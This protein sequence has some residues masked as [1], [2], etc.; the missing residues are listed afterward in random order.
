[1]HI[2]I[3]GPVDLSPLRRRIFGDDPPPTYSFPLVGQLA[4]ALLERGHSLSIF[5]GSTH[6]S[7]TRKFEGERLRIFACPLRPRRSA[8]DF[9]AHERKHLTRAMLESGCDLIHAHWTYE[10]SA[11]AIESGIPSLVTA[12]DSPL[13]ILRYFV[14]TRHFPFWTAKALLGAIVTRRA[15]QMTAVSPYCKAHIIRLLRPSAPIS[16]VPNGIQRQVLEMGRARL[17]NGEPPLPL[18]LATVLQGFQERKNPKTVLRAFAQI[19]RALPDATLKMYGTDYQ[20]GGA[21]D[22]WS[23]KH[24]LNDGVCF[25]G[26]IGHKALMQE[27]ISGVH[28][29]IHPA[30][31]ESFGMAPLEAMALGIPVIGGKSSGGVPYVLDNGQ[32]GIIVNVTDPGAIAQAVLG[33]ASDQT[34]RTNLTRAAW[35]RAGEEFSLDIMVE[36]YLA[37]YETVLGRENATGS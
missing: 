25:M 14:L 37:C 8:Y 36:R 18:V 33:L 28:I 5:A 23:R 31:E 16:V 32:A 29:L 1:M 19:R 21:A 12:H 13:A 6:V 10:F 22:I 20:S 17:A 30:K 24:H 35:K 15:R 9:Y 34:L 27:L 11:A 3:A 7:D 4:D 26:T 2:G